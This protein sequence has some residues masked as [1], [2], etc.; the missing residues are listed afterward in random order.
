[1]KSI[2]REIYLGKIDDY[3]KTAESEEYKKFDKEMKEKLNKLKSGFT[4]E[5]NKEFEEIYSLFLLLTLEHGIEHY[6]Q[7]FKRGMRLA[8]ESFE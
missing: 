2:I 6:K 4:E 8:V 7:G 3:E 5:Q 1:M